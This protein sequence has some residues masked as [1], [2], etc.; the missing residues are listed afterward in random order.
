TSPFVLVEQQRYAFARA[1]ADVKEAMVSGEK[2][3]VIIEGPPG[4]G[5]SVVAARIW[6]QLAVDYGCEALSVSM[7]GT[8]SS[9]TTNWQWLFKH[10]GQP[11]AGG[12]ILKANQF[13][14]YTASQVRAAK[15]RGVEWL[16][17]RIAGIRASVR[18]PTEARGA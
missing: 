3:V 12:F 4:S 13:I 7:V 17:R 5:K 11:A 14:P 10:H 16:D 2:R 18:L 6:A 1:M 15:E 9:Q 8:S